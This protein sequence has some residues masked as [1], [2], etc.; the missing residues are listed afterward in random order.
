MSADLDE[1]RASLEKSLVAVIEAHADALG[2]ERIE[3]PVIA[4]WVLVVAVDD[5]SDAAKGNVARLTKAH[6]FSHRTVGL[7][8]LAAESLK[9]TYFTDD[10]E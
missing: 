4:D 9:R 1:R 2:G 6:Q 10:E 7:L 3:M 5:V 8:E